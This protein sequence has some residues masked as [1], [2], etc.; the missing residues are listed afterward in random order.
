MIALHPV[1]FLYMD[2]D[3]YDASL[4]VNMSNILNVDC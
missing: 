1:L 2:F 4:F 3:Q